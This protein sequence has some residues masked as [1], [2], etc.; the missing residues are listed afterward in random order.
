MAESCLP[1]S[2]SS[3]DMTSFPP[4]SPLSRSSSAS[5]SERTMQPPRW[6]FVA[7]ETV[8][9]RDIPW[10]HRVREER[11]EEGSETRLWPCPFSRVHQTS[12]P[13][14]TRCPV[15]DTHRKQKA[16]SNS[17]FTGTERHTCTHQNTQARERKGRKVKERRAFQ[18]FLI[19]SYH[20]NHC[21]CD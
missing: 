19:Q 6:A 7:K 14:P 3:C 10:Q 12:G 16:Q 11:R 9:H 17:T 21:A 15:S 8:T 18:N 20:L 13:S 4:P 1:C 2:C 5:P